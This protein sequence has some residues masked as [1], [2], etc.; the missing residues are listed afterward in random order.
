MCVVE[1]SAAVVSGSHTNIGK[2]LENSKNTCFVT[3]VCHSITHENKSQT[4]LNVN[5]IQTDIG[6]LRAVL[7]LLLWVLKSS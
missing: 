4:F 3:R 7:T 1:H 6:I 2:L 5:V